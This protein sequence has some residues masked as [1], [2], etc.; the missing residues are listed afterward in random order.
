MRFL[1]LNFA[2]NDYYRIYDT[3]DFAMSLHFLHHSSQSQQ[4]K[5]LDHQCFRGRG[6]GGGRKSPIILQ[7]YAS[8]T[9]FIQE[10]SAEALHM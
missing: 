2:K 6:G 4:H 5:S 3:A 7:S 8:F 10:L 1:R 9:V